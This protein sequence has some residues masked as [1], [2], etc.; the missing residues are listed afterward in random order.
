MFGFGKR[1]KCFADGCECKIPREHLMCLLH[2]EMVPGHIQCEV[3]NTLRAW[4][5]GETPRPYLQAITR[6][7]IAVTNAEA[8]KGGKQ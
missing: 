8:R 7:K 6:A 1:K 2:W 3:N 4:Q 5:A